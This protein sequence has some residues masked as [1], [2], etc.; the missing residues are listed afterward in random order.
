MT[1]ISKKIKQFLAVASLSILG[2]SATAF[3]TNAADRPFDGHGWGTF[4][5]VV[6]SSLQHRGFRNNIDQSVRVF[7]EFDSL[8]DLKIGKNRGRANNRRDRRVI[9]DR[10]ANVLNTVA[11]GLPAGVRLVNSPRRADLIIKAIPRGYDVDFR[12]LDV[13]RKQKSRGSRNGR[14][15]FTYSKVTER[16]QLDYAYDFIVRVPGGGRFERR[17]GGKITNAFA[18]AD[19]INGFGPG[20]RRANYTTPRI[21]ELASRNTPQFRRGFV[22][23]LRLLAEQEVARKITRVIHAQTAAFFEPAS[24]Q[25]GVVIDLPNN[26]NGRPFPIQRRRSGLSDGEKVGIGIA[27]GVLA[28]LIADAVD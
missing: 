4:V 14:A 13:D 28:I 5:P 18:Y 12:V 22:Q 26:V 17:I 10:E 8:R 1:I 7:V 25:G 20:A 24:I 16:A 3:P 2:A 23:N 6:S 21:E 27:A 15:I 9:D 11:A 19:N